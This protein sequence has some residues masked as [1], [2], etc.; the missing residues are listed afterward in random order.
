MQLFTLLDLSYSFNK[1]EI[2]R[3]LFFVNGALFFACF[4]WFGNWWS[5]ACHDLAHG[6]HVFWRVGDLARCS[7]RDGLLHFSLRS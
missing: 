1:E 6:K 7:G 4:C 3:I 5:V 2:T